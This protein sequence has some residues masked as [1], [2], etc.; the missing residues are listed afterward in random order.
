LS[1]VT[2]VASPGA[3]DLRFG[4]AGE[5]GAVEEV[6]F[7][8][9]WRSLIKE[10]D[11]T[12]RPAVWQESLDEIGRRLV[13]SS[14][15]RVDLIYR[16]QI[17]LLAY[18]LSSAQ[19]HPGQ[20]VSITLFWQALTPIV[21]KYQV[22]NHLFGLDGRV[23]GEADEFP[24]VPTN[25]W[26]PGQVVTTTHQLLTDAGLAPPALASLDI[27]LYDAERRSLPATRQDGRRA[28]VTLARIKLVP[29]RWPDQRPPVKDEVLFG[30]RL[31][32]EG[33]ALAGDAA[34]GARLH[35]QLW[36]RVQAPTNVDYA[37]FVHLLDSAGNIVA[38]ADGA[39][40]NG[41]YPTSAWEVGETIVDARSLELPADLPAGE[42]QLILGLYNPVD[43]S[44]L[45]L[46][47]SEAQGA[48][49]VHLGRLSVN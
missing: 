13:P 30:D 11:G 35:V 28:P 7:P 34:P 25:R 20:P 23:V 12:W 1:L 49:F 31:L 46:A 9:G 19:V 38:Q 27:G 33:H 8:E 6:V 21:E 4:V 40:V 36:W 16:N 17:R 43:G 39:P 24:P 10:A 22:F 26:L 32:L 44:R 45:P 42:Y 14:A 3:Y 5:A 47:A 48:D 41:R 2:G 37:V 18:E 29:D 15:T